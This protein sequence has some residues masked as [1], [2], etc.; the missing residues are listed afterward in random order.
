MCKTGIKSKHFALYPKGLF[1][2]Y[3]HVGL[4]DLK[5]NFSEIKKLVGRRLAEKAKV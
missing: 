2:C 3:E 1:I 5:N 4:K